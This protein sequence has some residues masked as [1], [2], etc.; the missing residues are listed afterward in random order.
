MVENRLVGELHLLD[1]LVLRLLFLLHLCV[2]P[3][4]LLLE[5]PICHIQCDASS[6]YRRL[7]RPNNGGGGCTHLDLCGHTRCRTPD[8]TDGHFGKTANVDGKEA[9]VNV[10]IRPRIRVSRRIDG[11]ALERWRM[12]T[13]AQ[14]MRS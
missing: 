13:P 7:L 6:S 8:P 2:R 5:S 4:F 9:W 10:I 11:I 3:T 14:C 1:C 12:L